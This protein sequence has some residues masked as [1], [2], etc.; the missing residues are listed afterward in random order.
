[1]HSRVAV[2]LRARVTGRASVNR[3]AVALAVALIAT[4]CDRPVTPVGTT[5]VPAIVP[6]LSPSEAL[7]V[8]RFVT[9]EWLNGD[10]V[11]GCAHGP[12]TG[13]PGNAALRVLA[14]K[15]ADGSLLRMRGGVGDHLGPGMYVEVVREWPRGRGI[16]VGTFNLTTDSVSVLRFG[17]SGTGRTVNDHR[18]YDPE[19]ARALTFLHHRFAALECP[20]RLN[21]R[22][23]HGGLVTLWESDQP[24]D[25]AWRNEWP[26][27][28][29]PHR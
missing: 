29:F 4:G 24:Y 1:V 14:T 2:E 8:A 11:A 25:W 23:N 13:A 21:R 22:M 12:I 10:S 7:D 17:P 19:A 18:V 3:I 26:R 6:T 9:D 28:L 20:L 15:L 16:R 27:R 5:P